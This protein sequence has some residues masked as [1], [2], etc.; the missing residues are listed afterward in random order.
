MI[1]RDDFHQRRSRVGICLHV[2]VIRR[3]RPDRDQPDRPQ[4]D[5]EPIVKAPMNQSA[6]HVGTFYPSL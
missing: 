2:E 3:V 5:D 4:N 6:D 1:L